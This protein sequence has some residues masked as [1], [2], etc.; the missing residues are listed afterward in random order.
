MMHDVW[1]EKMV[2]WM[3]LG[4]FVRHVLVYWVEQHLLFRGRMP[5]T[6]R[7]KNAVWTKYLTET[8]S[9]MFSKSDTYLTGAGTLRTCII[10]QSPCLPKTC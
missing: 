10:V 2:F 6:L 1:F 5:G 7:I 4:A 8:E 9:E 3:Y